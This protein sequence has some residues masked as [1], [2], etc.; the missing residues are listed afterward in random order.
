MLVKAIE[1]VFTGELNEVF[2]PCSDERHQESV[3]TQ[4]FNLRNKL[5]GSR[6]D[7][8]GIQKFWEEDRT[9]CYVRIYKRAK[10]ELYERD[11]ETGKLVLAVRL[12]NE[13][14]PE[15]QRIVAKMREDRQGEDF[16][17]EYLDHYKPS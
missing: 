11:P 13:I 5:L 8:I 10:V 15:V 7:E 12:Q 17:K 4:T 3:R 16:I 9:L 2:I 6:K 14:D 1:K